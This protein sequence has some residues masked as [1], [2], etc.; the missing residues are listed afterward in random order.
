MSALKGQETN[1]VRCE[2]RPTSKYHSTPKFQNAQLQN[3]NIGIAIGFQSILVHSHCQSVD[4]RLTFYLEL[5]IQ[6]KILSEPQEPVTNI[7]TNQTEKSL[8]AMRP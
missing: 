5:T 8:T 3:D 1:A 2:S 7:R 4:L 6:N